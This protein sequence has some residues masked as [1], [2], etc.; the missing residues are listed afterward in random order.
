MK[1]VGL[2]DWRIITS[3]ISGFMAKESVVSVMET[4]FAGDVTSIGALSAA[5]MLVFSLIYTPC[6][7]AVAAFKREMGG[8]WALS[9]VIWQCALA[10]IMALIVRLAGILLGFG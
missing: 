7:A 6:V 5:S 10:W 2:G 9:L 1:P 4:L 8:K 3:L